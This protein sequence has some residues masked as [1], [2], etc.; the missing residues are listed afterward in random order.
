MRN[1]TFKKVRE[2]HI[3]AEK[4][5]HATCDMMADFGNMTVFG[6]VNMDRLTRLQKEMPWEAALVVSG[7]NR[8]Y[9]T[10]FSSSAGIL[11][12][13][14]KEAF[15]L[16]DARY[17]QA[18]EERVKNCRVVLEDGRQ[19]PKILSEQ[20]IRQIAFESNYLS[21]EAAEKLKE[22]IAPASLVWS[23]EFGKLLLDLRSRKDA[24]ELNCL[25]QAQSI[26]DRAFDRLLGQIHPGVS[27]LELMMFLGEEM[28]RLGCEKKSFNMIFTSGSR[29]ALPHGD[30]AIRTIEY[31]DFIMMDMRA[32]VGGY[33]ADMTR[34]VAVG[35]AADEQRQ[36]Y[37]IVLEAQK[38]ALNA[39]EPGK[40]CCEIDALAR[41]HIRD[42][43][44]GAFFGHGLGHSLGLEIH[45]D[46]RFNPQC[47]TRLQPGMVMTVEP[48][49]YI[50]D[51][52]G[53]RIED[54][55]TVTDSSCEDFTKSPKNLIVL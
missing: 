8:F 41:E 19:L 44:Y 28:A 51:K 52:F 11:L 20:N 43:G 5:F 23:N 40:A 25:R 22:R 32:M 39:I 7:V 29:T 21:V 50:P 13:T 49:I 15:L 16:V 12:L 47:T 38:R 35:T 48:G 4:E 53:I 42:M 17:I 9:L 27:E 55:V 2:K 14:K 24:Q 34:T 31:G 18:A 37:E 36:V 26:T 45:E 10:G 6:G 33:T 30:P 1:C 46:P 54:M 3:C